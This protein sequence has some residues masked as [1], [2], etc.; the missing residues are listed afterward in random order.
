MWRVPMKMARMGGRSVSMISCSPSRYGLVDLISPSRRLTQH[1][2]PR[3]HPHPVM[4]V[5]YV[6][7]CVLCVRV[8]RVV[9]MMM[10][11]AARSIDRK[12]YLCVA[13]ITN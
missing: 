12:Q 9:V 4:C 10:M 1:I 13:S 11:R 3:Q 7:A 8:C 6:R 5:L 2:A